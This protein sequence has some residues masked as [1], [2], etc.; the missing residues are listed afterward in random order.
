MRIVAAGAMVRTPQPHN[1]A[2]CICEESCILTLDHTK[3]TM[4]KM[5]RVTHNRQRHAQQV[6]AHP[7]LPKGVVDFGQTEV[8][9]RN[10]ERGQGGYAKLIGTRSA[11]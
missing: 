2:S 8:S 11:Y 4:P 9:P 6:A 3:E 5:D 10:F 1:A 7:Y